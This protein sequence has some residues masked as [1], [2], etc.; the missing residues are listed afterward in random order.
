MRPYRRYQRTATVITSGGNRNRQTPTGRRL[1][2]RLEVDGSGQLPL[3]GSAATART[4]DNATDPGNLET[5]LPLA[6]KV[7]HPPVDAPG[8][9]PTARD[10]SRWRDQTTLLRHMRLEHVV[11]VNEITAGPPPHRLGDADDSAVESVIVEMEWVEGHALSVA[12]RSAPTTAAN[13]RQRA[14]WVADACT[15][16]SQLHSHTRTAGNPTVHRDVTPANCIVRPDSELVLIDVSTLQLPRD[17]VD[18]TGRHT[19]PYSAPEVLAMPHNPRT[20]SADVYAIGALVYFCLTG[21]DPPPRATESNQGDR[22][23]R[24]L[25]A[26]V[27]RLALDPRTS[28]HVLRM[29]DP[30]PANRPTDLRAWSDRF[31]EL[32][33]PRRVV[34]TARTLRRPLVAAPLALVIA[35]CAVG[36]GLLVVDHDPPRSRTRA[37]EAV[38]P[39]PVA[40]TNGI[41][42]TSFSTDKGRIT[43]PAPGARV[44]NCEYFTGTASLR[45]GYTVMLAQHNLSE[46]DSTRYVQVVFGFDKPETVSTWRGAQYFNDNAVGQETSVELIELPLKDAIA[47]DRT[48]DYLKASR[49][50]TQGRVLAAV[51]VIHGRQQNPEFPCPGPD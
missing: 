25:R 29:L 49:L 32:A 17:G 48:D 39:T 24:S 22:L 28:E 20:P 7:Q 1:S 30:E 19:P 21:Q 38:R 9:W 23:E 16:L 44:R 26:V 31:V 27:D 10:Q 50:V 11:R 3:P 34:L 4:P 33:T 42:R 12:V 41:T 8:R 37:A 40:A 51:V 6:V 45:P 14:G 47:I 15:A 5:P 18:P 36:T 35:G 13:V 46:S 2:E 43:S